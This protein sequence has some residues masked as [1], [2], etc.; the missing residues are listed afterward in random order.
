MEQNEVEYI[1]DK[2]E[3]YDEGTK[4]KNRLNDEEVISSMIGI[5]L[6]CHA[7]RNQRRIKRKI[8]RNI[9]RFFHR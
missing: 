5:S 4:N 2:D 8:T 3:R 9:L 7:R 6:L 1:Y